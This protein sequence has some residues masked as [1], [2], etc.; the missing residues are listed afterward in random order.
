MAAMVPLWVEQMAFF[1]F[2]ASSTHNSCPGFTFIPGMAEI[3]I[4]VPGRGADTTRF[5]SISPT[6]TVRAAGRGADGEA[7]G[8][9]SADGRTTG[10]SIVGQTSYVSQSTFTRMGRTE[11]S[12]TSTSNI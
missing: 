5:L 8:F 12:P 7:A 1:I 11:V 2:I 10:A 3:E 9:S 4:I 6:E